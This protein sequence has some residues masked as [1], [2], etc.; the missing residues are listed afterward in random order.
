VNPLET[1]CDVKAMSVEQLEQRNVSAA[2]RES[3]RPGDGSLFSGASKVKS[4]SSGGEPVGV[5]TADETLDDSDC[6]DAAD[7]VDDE[8]D[9]EWRRRPGRANLKLGR[10]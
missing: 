2:V 5:V 1:I 8:D 10:R 7:D 3:R 6:V 4:R 9:A